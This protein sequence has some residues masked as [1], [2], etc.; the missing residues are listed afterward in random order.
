MRVVDCCFY[1][2]THRSSVSVKCKDNGRGQ[3]A[4]GWLAA[5]RGRGD[6]QCEWHRRERVMGESIYS[7]VNHVISNQATA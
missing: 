3:V 5:S 4:A 7:K 1:Y 2:D 6:V